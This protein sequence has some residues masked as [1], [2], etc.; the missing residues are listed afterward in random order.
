MLICVCILI[1]DICNNKNIDKE[2]FVA[3]HEIVP[4]VKTKKYIRRTKNNMQSSISSMM[5]RA[6][7]H[8]RSWLR[9]RNLINN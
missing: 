3:V 5:K 1:M 4:Y 7:K 9:D 6:R 2:G 8:T